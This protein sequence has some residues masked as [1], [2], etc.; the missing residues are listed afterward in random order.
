MIRIKYRNEL[1]EFLSLTKFGRDDFQLS[2][3]RIQVEDA[4]VL[5]YK[6]TR[7]KFYVANSYHSYEEFKYAETYYAPS[8]PVTQFLPGRHPF[9]AFDKVLNALNTWM[10]DHVA[11]YV[12]DQTATDLWSA[13]ASSTKLIDWESVA[14]EQPEAFSPDEKDHLRLALQELKGLIERQFVTTAAEQ[15][16]VNQRIDYL[17]AGLDRLNKFDWKSVVVNTIIS[18]V[19]ALSFDAEKG[20]QLYALFKRMLSTIRHLT[21]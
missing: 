14:F 16:T 20:K 9:L 13:Y 19:I 18:I 12:A 2:E 15:Q 11:N 4:T 6:D 5:A 17:A 1:F 10:N 8:F 21:N 3:E 7:L